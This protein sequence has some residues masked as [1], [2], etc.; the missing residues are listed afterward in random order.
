MAAG[1]AESWYHEKESAWFY[2]VVAPAE[3]DRAKRTSFG[4]LLGA[5]LAG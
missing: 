1:A 5:N 3:R 2:G 4:K